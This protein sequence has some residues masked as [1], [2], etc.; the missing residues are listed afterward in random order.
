MH[1]R[2][3][4][5]WRRQV[6]WKGCNDTFQSL[7]WKSIHK[8]ISAATCSTKPKRHVASTTI[9]NKY[10][11]TLKSVFKTPQRAVEIQPTAWYQL[12]RHR[13]DVMTFDD[14]RR[15]LNPLILK[16]VLYSSKLRLL[17]SWY[18][19]QFG[20]KINPREVMSIVHQIFV[21]TTYA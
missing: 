9:R 19:K 17:I 8:I 12:K 4:K 3:F 20:S 13:F 7:V 1:T 16:P 15:I 10:S 2:S 14:L 6:T 21:H 5:I 18:T 11:E